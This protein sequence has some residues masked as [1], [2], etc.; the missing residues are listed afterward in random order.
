MSYELNVGDKIPAFS[1]KDH[2]GLEIDSDDLIGSPFVLYFYP[3]DDTPGCT[4][5]ACSFR[6]NM[7]QL[8]DLDTLVIGVSPDSADSHVKFMQKYGLNFT[9]LCDEQLEL[10]RKFGAVQ[11]K[12]K[13]GQK[14]LAILRATFVVDS[15]GTIRWLEK[16]VS[17]EGHTERVLQAL[18]QGIR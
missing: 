9:L 16:P 11:E 5:E 2:E 13:D 18:S 14:M 7:P 17:V 10:A 3:K 6:D 4:K 15:S 8:D 1:I 12:E